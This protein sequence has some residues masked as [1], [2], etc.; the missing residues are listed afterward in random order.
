[1]NGVGENQPLRGYNVSS[2]AV[3]LVSD[4]KSNKGFREIFKL[5]GSQIEKRLVPAPSQN[6]G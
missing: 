6:P 4:S 1:M 2:S 5:G 3:F